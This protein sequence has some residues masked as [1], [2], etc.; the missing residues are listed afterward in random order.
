MEQISLLHFYIVVK[1][2]W[3]RRAKM[4]LSMPSG[5]TCKRNCS[6]LGI[7]AGRAS[8]RGMAGEISVGR[9]RHHRGSGPERRI[10]SREMRRAVMAEGPWPCMHRRRGICLR[11]HI[12]YIIYR[13]KCRAVHA[14]G[15]APNRR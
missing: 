3:R 14:A 8:R 4:S 9:R 12:W 5:E 7:V 13:M 11:Y 15:R 10:E 2:A 6:M 1:R